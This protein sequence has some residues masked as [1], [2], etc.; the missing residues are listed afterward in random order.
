MATTTRTR[1]HHSLAV[2]DVAFCFSPRMHFKAV[3]VWLRH[4]HRWLQTMWQRLR[5]PGQLRW[6]QLW[7]LVTQRSLTINVKHVVIPPTAS[8]LFLQY[9]MGRSIVYQNNTNCRFVRFSWFNVLHT[10]DIPD[11]TFVGSCNV[12]FILLSTFGW[13]STICCSKWLNTALA[14]ITTVPG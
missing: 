3:P 10:Q 5:L 12:F 9:G 4:V 6:T 7:Q 2:V 11:D 13:M 1:H 14:K 8:M